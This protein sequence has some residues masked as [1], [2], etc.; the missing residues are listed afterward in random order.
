MM[1]T[2]AAMGIDVAGSASDTP[3]T[4]TTAS[5][6]AREHQARSDGEKN[7]LALAKDSDQGEDEE[8]P[9]AG[10]CAAVAPC[11]TRVG[12][13]GSEVVNVLTLGVEC[14]LEFDAPLCSRTLHFKHGH[15]HNEDH[16]R[17]NELEYA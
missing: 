17:G 6:P 11:S 2:M 12:R 4:K 7:R 8:D 13:H 3:P 1:P 10:F 5:R 14:I 15:A 16:E 9:F